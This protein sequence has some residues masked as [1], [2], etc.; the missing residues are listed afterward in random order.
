MNQAKPLP[1]P[2][3]RE[4]LDE[5]LEYAQRYADQAGE[6]EGGACLRSIEAAEDLLS[7]LPTVADLI[8]ALEPATDADRVAEIGRLEA[9]A[10]GWISGPA[11]WAACQPTLAAKLERLSADAAQAELANLVAGA[12][13][14]DPVARADDDGGA[15]IAARSA[16]RHARMLPGA[17]TEAKLRILAALEALKP[18]QG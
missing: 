12:G 5:V 10:L 1:A 14:S 7:T 6:V 4:V 16:L 11:A 17:S 3:L 2:E 9:E 13:T 15:I 18:V 8:D